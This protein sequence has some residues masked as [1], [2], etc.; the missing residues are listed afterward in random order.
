[1]KFQKPFVFFKIFPF[2]EVSFTLSFFFAFLPYLFITWSHF[3][4]LPHLSRISCLVSLHFASFLPFSMTQSPIENAVCSLGT[5]PSS[6]AS[7]FFLVPSCNSIPV[8]SPLPGSS[9]PLLTSVTSRRWRP[10]LHHLR[11]LLS[12]ELTDLSQL[13]WSS[14]SC[15]AL[16][17]CCFLPVPFVHLLRELFFYFPCPWVAGI[18]RWICC[19]YLRRTQV[20]AVYFL[21]SQDESIIINFSWNIEL[22]VFSASKN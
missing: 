6:P 13:S 15:S 5:P 1:M 20:L 2:P 21:G 18:S 10:L 7:P 17:L 16:H 3:Y 4:I 22:P 8:L 14:D 19:L 12:V 11:L 9:S